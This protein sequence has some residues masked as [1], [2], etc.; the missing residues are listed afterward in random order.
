LLVFAPA[1]VLS[2][3]AMK[4]KTLFQG[5]IAGLLTISLAGAT[6]A[7]GDGPIAR[8]IGDREISADRLH[9]V[10]EPL[11]DGSGDAKGETRALLV[12]HDGK[13]VAERYA[14]GY[15]P[16]SRMLSWSVAKTVTAIL[17]GIMV[18]DGRLALDDPAPVPAWSQN[19]DPRGAITLRQMLNMTSG[20]THK[21]REGPLEDTDTLRMLVGDGAADMAR[22]AETKPL[23]RA[24]GSTWLYSTA[25]TLTLCDMMTRMLT[26]S[27]APR[28]RRN[29]MMGFVEQR[30]VVPMHL[31]SL[32][33]EFDARGTMIGGAMM[34]MTA[35][36][37]AKIGEFLR[38][39]GQV[40]GHQIV[41]ESWVRFMTS[42]SRHNAGYGG[43][44]WLNHPR[45]EDVLFVGDAPSSLYAAN[46]LR[47]QYVIVSPRQGL[48]IVRLG[49]TSDEDMPALRAALLRIIDR[50]PRT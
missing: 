35:P 43:H 40:N 38:H 47:G 26:D 19:G 36:D 41:S 10:I 49:V 44:L 9:D 16:D 15:G 22:F 29:A 39:N 2:A 14:P 21:E 4:I 27:D 18:S 13:L 20:I 31:N 46:G 12:L 17:V 33:P 8:Y 37:Y 5:A 50:V 32:V 1:A 42:P 25:T 11:F 7:A 34:H 6:P 48:T 24:P 3:A 45:A 23:A 28:D 30:L